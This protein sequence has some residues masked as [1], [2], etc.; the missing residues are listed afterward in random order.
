MSARRK[1]R[2]WAAIGS[3]ALAYRRDK[4]Y[5]INFRIKNPP[6]AHDQS[7]V[8]LGSINELDNWKKTGPHSHQLVKVDDT[9]WESQ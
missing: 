5:E 9:T 7:L 2:N 3:D 6:V 1:E 4:T 8:V